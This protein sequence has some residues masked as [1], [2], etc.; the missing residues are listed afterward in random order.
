MRERY[1]LHVLAACARIALAAL[2]SAACVP[3][4]TASPTE[5]PRCADGRP[6]SEIDFA[7][8]MPIELRSS[9]I[10]CIRIATGNSDRLYKL[11]DGRS[12]HLYE[13]VGVLPAK[14]TASPLAQGSRNLNGQSWSWTR[15]NGSVALSATLNGT[16]V[17]LGLPESG[18]TPRDVDDLARLSGGLA[19]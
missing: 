8:A 3:A 12:L 11:K 4:A 9:E 17:E 13:Y 18:D 19:R 1:G 16:Y 15:V 5:V 10:A 14:P 6:Q 2:T 7:G